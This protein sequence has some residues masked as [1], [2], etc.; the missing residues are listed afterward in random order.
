MK[1]DRKR[2]ASRENKGQCSSRVLTHAC[3]HDTHTHMHTRHTCMHTCMTHVYTMHAAHDTHTYT[4][5]PTQHTCTHTHM[6]ADAHTHSSP[7]SPGVLPTPT[8]GE[9]SRF[10]FGQAGLRCWNGALGLVCW[11]RTGPFAPAG[12]YLVTLKEPPH[13]AELLVAGE[14]SGQQVGMPR[15]REEKSADGPGRGGPGWVS[16]VAGPRGTSSKGLSA[17]GYSQA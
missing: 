15:G 5:M 11:V 3:T 17:D 2:K 13:Q 16:G 4:H 1:F 8:T 9:D 14:P 6:H 10:F 7:S 12:N